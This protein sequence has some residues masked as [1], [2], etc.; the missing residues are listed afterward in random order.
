MLQ[1][2]LVDLAT[3]PLSPELPLMK[4]VVI[5]FAKKDQEG[6]I[7]RSMLDF[8]VYMNIATDVTCVNNIFMNLV[9]T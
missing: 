2:S 1:G 3:G 5:Q 7:L 4:D 6:K 9:S 8:F